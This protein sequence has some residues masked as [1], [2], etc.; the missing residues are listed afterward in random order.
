[1]GAFACGGAGGGGGGAG[2]GDRG[3]GSVVCYEPVKPPVT[4]EIRFESLT[5][6]VHAMSPCTQPL[7][8]I[9]PCWLFD[10]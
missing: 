10:T 7:P 4:P 1:M 9:D 5:D 3:W 8:P 2:E 6:N